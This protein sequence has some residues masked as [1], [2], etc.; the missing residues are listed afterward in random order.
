MSD[1]IT[2]PPRPKNH[3]WIYFFVFVFGASIFVALFMIWYNRSIQLTQEQL[4]A[5]KTRWQESKIANY[6]MVFKK[7]LLNDEDWTT[8][9][10]KV[11]DSKV[12]EV[13]MNGKPLAPETDGNPD[14]L[15][16]HGMDAQFHYLEKFLKL[17]QEAKAP[18]VYFVADFDQKTGAIIR[19]TRYDRSKNQRVEMLFNLQIL[20]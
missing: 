14:P 10:V 2:P 16:Y 17:D 19:Y 7:R 6:N 15:P 4:D 5:A 8:F 12:Q 1:S 3:G 11:R 9:H 18:K 13:L 20:K